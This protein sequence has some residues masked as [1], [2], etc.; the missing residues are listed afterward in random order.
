VTIR[1]NGADRETEAGTIAG[2][3]DELSLPRQTVLLERNGE[4]VT[5]EQWE[6][7]ALK[8][9]DQIEILRVAAGG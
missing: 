5:R 9:G 4:P 3:I 6:E 7:L 8:N 2:L 1:L